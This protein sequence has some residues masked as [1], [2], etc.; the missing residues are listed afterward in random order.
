MNSHEQQRRKRIRRSALLFGFIALAFYVGFIVLSVV[1]NSNSNAAA[2][3]LPRSAGEGGE[4]A[5]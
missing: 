5:S 2:L 3:P 4:G 1:R